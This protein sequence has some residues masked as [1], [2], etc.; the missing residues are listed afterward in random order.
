[1]IVAI[2]AFNEAVGS[3]QSLRIRGQ[4]IDYWQQR[5]IPELAFYPSATLPESFRF[6]A[7]F[8]PD[9]LMILTEDQ[10]QRI[11][12]FLNGQ[13]AEIPGVFVTEEREL[14]LLTNG[15]I[16][17]NEG[18]LHS[19]MISRLQEILQVSV[20][21]MTDQILSCSAIEDSSGA[22]RMIVDWQIRQLQKSGIRLQDFNH[23]YIEGG[24]EIGA[25]TEIGSG[26]VISGNSS[27]GIGAVIHPHCLV[28]HAQIGDRAELLP[29]TIVRD[30]ILADEVTIGPYAHIRNQTVIKK[31]AKI[32]NFVEFKKSTFG[33][34][35]KAMHLSYIG[36]AIVGREVNIGAG[37]ITCN[38]DG[39]TKNPTIIEDLVFIGSGT[40]LVAP[41][42]IERNAYIGAGSTIT[43]NVPA[44]S[45]AI[46]RER[47]KNLIDWVLRKAKE[48]KDQ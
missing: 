35:S 43:Q 16:R 30:S 36:D 38:Y 1:M 23:F 25:G 12:V 4:S 9:C 34:G 7:V 33:E 22:E 28:D 41:V 32:G 48:K 8:H 13:S 11:L 46:A 42:T 19:P 27:I 2:S 14:F 24:C 6:L 20:I 29:G 44:N 37:T 39:R 10:L 18:W 17:E 5:F 47:Q 3:P 45:L 26:V 21:P 15:F 31:G 40:E